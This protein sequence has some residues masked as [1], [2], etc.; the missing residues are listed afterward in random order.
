MELYGITT[1]PEGWHFM[2]CALL[3]K[4]IWLLEQVQSN[5]ELKS[6]LQALAVHPSGLPCSEL[7]SIESLQSFLQENPLLKEIIDIDDG[8]ICFSSREYNEDLLRETDLKPPKKNDATP[9]IE[10]YDQNII[11]NLEQHLSSGSTLD[12]DFLGQLL[13]FYLKTGSMTNLAEICA[14]QEALPSGSIHKST[15]NIIEQ[16]IPLFF[17]QTTDEFADFIPPDFSGF[18]GSPGFSTAL[19]RHLYICCKNLCSS[20]LF[21]SLCPVL[22]NVSKHDALFFI[23]PALHQESDKMDSTLDKLKHILPEYADNLIEPIK[24]CFR[25]EIRIEDIPALAHEDPEFKVLSLFLKSIENSN[26][27][28]KMMDILNSARTEALQNGQFIFMADILNN[29]SHCH[30]RQGNFD[31]QLVHYREAVIF[32]QFS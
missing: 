20:E 16:L 29:L 2:D 4:R 25:G 14:M 17:A 21:F 11:Y 26:N 28:E 6:A 31:Q 8:F 7:N 23:R 3:Q 1:I 30:E 19:F 10:Q 9:S 22:T 32:E 27:T 18:A 13:L 5:K 15:M 24:K 12:D